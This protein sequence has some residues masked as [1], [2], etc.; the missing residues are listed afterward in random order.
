MTLGRQILF[1]LCF[2]TI[3]ADPFGLETLRYFLSLITKARDRK[4]PGH[5]KIQTIKWVRQRTYWGLKQSKEYVDR[6]LQDIGPLDRNHFRDSIL[7]TFE[8]KR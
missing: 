2:R 8:G 1:F 6:I 7:R 3:P 4:Y 5:E